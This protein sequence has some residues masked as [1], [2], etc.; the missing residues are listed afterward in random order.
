MSHHEPNPYLIH[1]KLLVL[2][3]L[4]QGQ[5]YYFPCVFTQAGIA[6]ALR[7]RQRFELYMELL[8][9]HYR[10]PI[11]LVRGPTGWFLDGHECPACPMDVARRVADEYKDTI[12]KCLG[13]EH[14]VVVVPE[15]RNILLRAA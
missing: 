3:P 10:T 12:K 6:Q 5:P 1:L 11:E 14:V 9:G 2:P 7:C 8:K 13:L 4:M 15:E